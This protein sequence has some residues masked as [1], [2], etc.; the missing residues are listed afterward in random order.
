MVRITLLTDLKSSKF[1]VQ[2]WRYAHHELFVIYGWAKGPEE[3]AQDELFW[4]R[5]RCPAG[6]RRHAVIFNDKKRPQFMQW[7]GPL[8]GAA[9][10]GD[11]GGGLDKGSVQGLYLSNT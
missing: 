10:G 1:K 4:P 2:S 6:N 11:P 8:G 3:L 7:S 9:R 5:I